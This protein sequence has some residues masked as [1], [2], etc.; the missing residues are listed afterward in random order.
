[1]A[2]ALR[3]CAARVDAEARALGARPAGLTAAASALPAAVLTVV[4]LLSV[5]SA[6][7]GVL[8]SIYLSPVEGVLRHEDASASCST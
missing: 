2:A 4:A 8:F 1:P 3:G 7:G 6:A 5:P